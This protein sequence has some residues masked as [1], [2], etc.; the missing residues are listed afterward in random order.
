MLSNANAWNTEP[1]VPSTEKNKFTGQSVK[2]KLTD[3][4]YKINLY[5]TPLA[6]KWLTALEDNL[7]KKRILEKNFCFL[8]FATYHR[9]LSYLVKE[10]NENI[11][12]INDF[13]FKE[14][15]EFIHP[16]VNDDFQYSRSL[17]VGLDDLGLCLKHEACNLLHR[18]FEDLQGT[19]SNLSPYYKQADNDTKYAI[20]Q[21][22]NLCHEIEGWV[23]SYWSKVVDPEWLRPSQITTFLNAP[24]YELTNQ[25]LELFKVNRY[26]RELGG[27][28]L[29]WSQI[30]KTLY[31]VF[32][33]EKGQ[34]LDEATC[35][36]ITHQRYYS[37]EFDIEWGKSVTEELNYF[38]KK[39]MDPYRTWLKDN[40]FDWDDPKLSLGYIKLGQV[41]L[42]GSFGTDKFLDVYEI[43]CNNLDIQE[44]S[45]ENHSCKYP[46]TLNSHDWKQIQLDELKQGYSKWTT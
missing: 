7:I 41:D 31:E 17:G 30:G 38:K 23:A 25:D 40:G 29:H 18:Y 26:D 5:D 6:Y 44:I 45:T 15:Y 11:R 27:V 22:N 37:G 2:V 14:P 33:D 4:E 19:V 24:R 46:Y 42:I 10:L 21:L 20:R 32:R 1:T 16:F 12:Q 3:L 9:D 34:K 13:Q 43:M 35:S 36:A 8:G 28:Y 39:E